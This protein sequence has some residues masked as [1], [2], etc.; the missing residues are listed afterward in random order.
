MSYIWILSNRIQF[1]FLDKCYNSR[2]VRGERSQHESNTMGQ[3]LV[4]DLSC[5]S[6]ALV[7]SIQECF[8][9]FCLYG[10]KY[11]LKNDI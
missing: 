1:L 9:D 8:W 7:A 4:P 6:L 2:E 5:F 3:N 10:D 11:I